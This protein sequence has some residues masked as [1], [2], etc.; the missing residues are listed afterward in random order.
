MLCDNLLTIHVFNKFSIVL[1]LMKI[2]LYR[3]DSDYLFLTKLQR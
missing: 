3:I 2:A 1:F